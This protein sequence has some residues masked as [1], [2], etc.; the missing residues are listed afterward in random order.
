M[1]RGSRF[2]LLTVLC[3]VPAMLAAGCG[4]QFG[5][6]LYFMGVIPSE[7]VPAEFHLTT[8]RLLILIDDDSDQ[9]SQ[10][11]VFDRLTKQIA[12]ELA[13]Y[14]D[15]PTRVIPYAQ[16]RELQQ[17]ERDFSQYTA[18][19]IGKLLEA[20]EVLWIKVD[21][22]QP[23]SIAATDVSRSAQFTVNLRLLDTHAETRDEVQ[24]W[25]ESREPRRVSEGLSLAFVQEKNNDR[26]VAEELTDRLAESITLIF[27]DHEID[28]AD[29]NRAEHM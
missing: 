24:I 20:D 27:V 1:N 21:V 11:E 15:R 4:Q 28:P 2:L 8:G 6:L 12:K 23:G 29:A 17:R 25:P 9:V 5:A 22:F 13:D 18:D 19:H 16:V 26:I 7:K 10:P 14:P 3:V